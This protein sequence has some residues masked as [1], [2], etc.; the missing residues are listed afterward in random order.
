[1]KKSENKYFFLKGIKVGMPICLGY[2]AVSFTLGITARNAGLT[3]WQAFLASLT[4]NASA[5]QY[6]GF[7][8]IAAAGSYMEMAIMELVAN[9]RYLLMSCS[10]S[11]KLGSETGLLH[12]LMV[13]FDVTDEIFGVSVSVPGK[14]NPFYNY[15]MMAVAIPGWSLGT[16]FGVIMGNV[17]PDNIVSA[18][19]VGL[20]GM[21]IAIIIPPARKNKVLAGL[22]I[23][24]MASS[25]FFSR[26]PL[27]A[28]ISPGIRTIILTVVIAGI[29]AVLFPVKEDSAYES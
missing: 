17:L 2:L 10:L 18:L 14:L 29:A 24:S 20:Y 12:R 5:G 22:I 11:Q 6:A 21:F 9:A 27:L 3:A 1:M 13:G 7:T 26:Q 19:S 28:Q 25:F 4:T 8:V 23:I 15:G 16:L